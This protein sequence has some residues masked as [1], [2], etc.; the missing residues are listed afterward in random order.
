MNRPRINHLALHLL[1]STLVLGLWGQAQKSSAKPGETAPAANP[2]ETGGNAESQPTPEDLIARKAIPYR[3]TINRDPFS[4]P[5]DAEPAKRGDM[6]DD[7]AVKGI[8]KREGKFFAVVTDSRGNVRFLPS[9]YKFRDG[10]IVSVDDKAVTFH[11][12]D[13]NSTV[14]TQ[15]KTITKTFKRE[16]GK[17]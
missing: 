14:K 16:E 4:A 2:A 6:V 13:P 11:Q 7:I 3:P 1:A 9:G 10:E 17:R 8:I 15:Y 12:W 5:S